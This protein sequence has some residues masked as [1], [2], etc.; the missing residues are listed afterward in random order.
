MN[1]KKQRKNSCTVVP[2]WTR[3]IMVKQKHCRH[4]RKRYFYDVKRWH[5]CSVVVWHFPQAAG[6]L[7]TLL[8]W[9]WYT[10]F[11]IYYNSRIRNQGLGIRDQGSGKREQGAG[12]MDQGTVIR[13]Q[14]TGIRDQRTGNCELLNGNWKLGTGNCEKGTKN[15][16]LGLVKKG[17]KLYSNVPC[18]QKLLDK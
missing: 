9:D 10:L 1:K 3:E 4:V 15:W 7:G 12:S 5:Y 8:S 13:D 18:F 14:E 2:M 16:E 17:N 11:L 6:R